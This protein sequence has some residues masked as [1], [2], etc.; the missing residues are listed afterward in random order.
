MAEKEIP[1]IVHNGESL[2]LN[3]LSD[4]DLLVRIAVQ[5]E[6]LPEIESRLRSTEDWCSRSRERWEQHEKEHKDLNVKKWAADIIGSV[7]AMIVGITVR[8]P[9][10]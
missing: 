3:R 6:T 10:P 4:H 5:V 7:A 8:P 1:T 9:T 2:K